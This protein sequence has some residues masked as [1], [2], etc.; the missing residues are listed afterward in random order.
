MQ[1]NI[2]RR[3][4]PAAVLD[5][6]YSISASII[7]TVLHC[8]NMRPRKPIKKLGFTLAIMKAR[9]KFALKYKDWTIED[10]KKVI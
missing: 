10:W 5:Q 8:N 3:K 7:L 6:K 4:K 1:K 2:N 9:Y